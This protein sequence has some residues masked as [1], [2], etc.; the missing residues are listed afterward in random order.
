M[1]INHIFGAF[2]QGMITRDSL[3]NVSAFSKSTE[4]IFLNSDIP[5]SHNNI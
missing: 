2:G 3:E 4:L 5:F 1:C